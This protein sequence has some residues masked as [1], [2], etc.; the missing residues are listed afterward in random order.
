MKKYIFDKPWITEG[1]KLSRIEKFRL[2]DIAKESNDSGDYNKYKKYLNHYNTF[3][4]NKARE[5]YY[6]DRAAALSQDKY[7]T[8]HWQLI[9]ELSMRKNKKKT[10][11]KSL[12]NK[13]GETL[14][15]PNE[16]ADCLN[17]HFG[18]VGK[19]MAEKFENC[20][21]D[22]VN[23]PLEY[24]C[25]EQTESMYL[26]ETDEYEIMR[27]ISSL[28]AGKACGYDHISNKIVKETSNVIVPYL[29]K[30]FNSC[31]NQGVF[32]N[33][34]KVAQV[35]PLFKGGDTENLNSYRPISLLPVLG[36]LLEKIISVR[37]IKFLEKFNLL[38][39]NQFSFRAKFSSEYAVLDD[40]I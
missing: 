23:D 15:A 39:E 27:L 8:W 14:S 30:L 24:V 17:E 16:I 12:K 31:M 25:V 7:K 26:Y 4:K 40:D 1:F 19:E 18:S 5:N 22:V 37:T 29:T 6:A 3:L 35:T 21:N 32:P 9:N 28:Q 34:Y 33:A 20:E 13:N 10:S 36:K 38:S 11:I 2:L